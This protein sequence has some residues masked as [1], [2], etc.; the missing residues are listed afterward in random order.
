MK[1][2]I[3]IIVRRK[4]PVIYC[5]AIEFYSHPLFIIII[6]IINTWHIRMVCGSPRARFCVMAWKKYFQYHKQQQ[7]QYQHG[8]PVQCVSNSYTIVTAEYLACK[9]R[10]KKWF[11]SPPARAPS[12]PHILYWAYKTGELHRVLYYLLCISVVNICGCVYTF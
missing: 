12:P 9:K 8:I 11:N 4:F 3:I 1:W 10:E 6:T 7:H 5:L 2:C